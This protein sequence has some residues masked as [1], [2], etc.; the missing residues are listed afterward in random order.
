MG[1][2]VIRD[3]KFAVISRDGHSMNTFPVLTNLSSAMA[4][5]NWLSEIEGLQPCYDLQSWSLIEPFSGGYRLPTQEEW[6]WAATGG[7][8]LKDAIPWL[9][10]STQRT[11]HANCD[12]INALKLSTAPYLSPVGYYGSNPGEERPELMDMIG[13]ASE[14]VHPCSL[15]PES[16]PHFD[17]KDCAVLAVGGDWCSCESEAFE[18]KSAWA[19]FRVLKRGDLR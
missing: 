9:S 17:A 5:C 6:L 14:M 15:G 2:L 12:R 7:R 16:P 18:S 19:G 8:P 4:F 3:G 1:Q 13:N 11:S 10:D